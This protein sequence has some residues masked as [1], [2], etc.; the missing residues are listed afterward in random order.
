MTQANTASDVSGIV[1]S[2]VGAGLNTG[3]VAKSVLDSGLALFVYPER[4]FLIVG[5][6]LRRDAVRPDTIEAVLKRRVD[7]PQ[8]FGPWLPSRFLDGSFFVLRRI[9]RAGT[10]SPPIPSVAEF[11]DAL[12]LLAS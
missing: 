10:E 8:R 2:L 11:G 4:E 3:A 5:V 1:A 12:A 6:G 9:P 7:V